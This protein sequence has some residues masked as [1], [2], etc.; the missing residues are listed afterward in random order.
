MD[1]I[2]H[3]FFKSYK[4]K[5]KQRLANHKNTASVSLSMVAHCCIDASDALLNCQTQLHLC[6]NVWGCIFQIVD[7]VQLRYVSPR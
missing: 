6:Q 3:L 5:I 4:L 2:A 1:G 7:I